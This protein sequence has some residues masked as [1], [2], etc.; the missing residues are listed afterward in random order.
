MSFNCLLTSW[1]LLCNWHSSISLALTNCCFC[2][3]NWLSNKATFSCVSEPP[4]VRI[5]RFVQSLNKSYLP[6]YVLPKKE[7]F[8][9][10]SN[11]IWHLRHLLGCSIHIFSASFASR[12]IPH[13]FLHNI[14]FFNFLVRFPISIIDL[15]PVA[16][17]SPDM[18]IRSLFWNY[19]TFFL[20][21][22]WPDSYFSCPIVLFHLLQGHHFARHEL[23]VSASRFVSG[24][25]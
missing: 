25:L 8:T 15:E 10:V 13:F 20:S 6:Q 16:D 3:R 9:F 11:W 2:C 17:V 22:D 5:M 4:H 18:D 21:H 23:L 7:I 12:T 14:C 24:D 1:W 19:K